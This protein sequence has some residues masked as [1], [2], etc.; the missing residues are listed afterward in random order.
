MDAMF[1]YWQVMKTMLEKSLQVGQGICRQ[2]ICSICNQFEAL[3]Q[4]KTD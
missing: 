2:L 3:K 1:E 4:I